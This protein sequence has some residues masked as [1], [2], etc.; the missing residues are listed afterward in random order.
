MHQITIQYITEKNSAPKAALLRKWAKAALLKR[1]NA[2]EVTVRIVDEDEM[3]QLNSQ[4]RHK[5]GPTNVLSF[6]FEMPKDVGIEMPILG[7][8]VICAAVVNQE[9]LNQGK[10]SEAH[11]AHMIVHGILHLLGYDHVEEEEARVM[12]G[13]EVQI[14]HQ[15]GFADPYAVKC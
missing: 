1:A 12:E 6:P 13:L 4:Y 7:D 11:W 9:A 10:S 8:I 15:L 2:S 3:T 14:L 5:Q